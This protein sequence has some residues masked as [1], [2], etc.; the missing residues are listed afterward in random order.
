MELKT[1]FVPR[2]RKGQCRLHY[3]TG[4]Q[5]QAGYSIRGPLDFQSSSVISGQIIDKR[6][7]L[8]GHVF[9]TNNGPFLVYVECE[10]FVHLYSIRLLFPIGMRCNCN[11]KSKVDDGG[12]ELY[13]S[14]LSICLFHIG[15]QELWQQMVAVA[16]R[17]SL[18]FKFV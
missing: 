15:L 7:K 11:D 14:V 5:R 1:G 16:V 9:K 13:Y 6:P 17:I 10:C 12:R 3:S 8:S 4:S 2:Y 18:K